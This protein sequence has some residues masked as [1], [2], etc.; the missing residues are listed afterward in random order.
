VPIV[1]AMEGKSVQSSSAYRHDQAEPGTSSILIVDDDPASIQALGG[2]LT[3]FGEL[4]FALSGEEALSLATQAPPDLVLLDVNMPGMSG[5]DV[6]RRLKADPRLCET[7][8]VFVTGHSD[9]A[10][11]V[12]GLEAGAVDFISKPL[13]QPLVV[14]RVRTQ[15][16]LRQLTEALRQSARTDGLTGLANR[17]SFDEELQH[18]WRRACRRQEPLSL[19]LLDIDHFKAFNDHYGHP[20][21][22][23]CLQAVARAIGAVIR[24]PSDLAARYGGEEFAVV[25]P[26]TDAGGAQH[27]A[28]N[29]VRAVAALEIP[30]AASPQARH[31]TISAG[32]TTALRPERNTQPAQL[33]D[34][35]DAALYQAKH[36]G[37]NQAVFTA[38]SPSGQAES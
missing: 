3:P 35:A 15:L 37:R 20:A 8:V 19:V 1:G 32:A 27:I 30:H 16:R 36:L 38:F 26:A 7:P 28:Q 34:A 12:T 33:I 13:A 9:L 17:R 6:C 25:L 31:V 10:S 24:R 29:L 23:R 11:E 18:E 14:A 5:F 21:G 4:R 22:D 2:M